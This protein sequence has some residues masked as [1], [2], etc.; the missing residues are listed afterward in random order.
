MYSRD[1]FDC[2]TPMN[3]FIDSDSFDP[4][5]VNN[6]KIAE[7]L[8][9]FRENKQLRYYKTKEKTLN[10][11]LS[12][13]PDV[14]DLLENIILGHCKMF[15]VDY[16]F[17]KD[18]YFPD[19][20][21][22][23]YAEKIFDDYEHNAQTKA[24]IL[25]LLAHNGISVGGNCSI[26][27]TNDE[28]LLSHRNEL[29]SHRISFSLFGLKTENSICIF[30]LNEASL[31]LDLFFKANGHYYSKES[32]DLTMG[33]WYHLSSYEKMPHI[34]GFNDP[35]MT[36]LFNR[37]SFA[38]HCL[39]EIGIQNFKKVT[40][41]N[42]YITIYNLTYLIS[43][44]TGIFDNL[45][46]KTASSL[47]FKTKHPEVI[48][49]KNNQKK[50]RDYVNVEYPKLFEYIHNSD[51]FISLIHEFREFAIHREGFDS[52]TFNNGDE[53]KGFFTCLVKLP[54]NMNNAIDLIKKNEGNSNVYYPFSG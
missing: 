29:L 10:P 45:A 18:L 43:L 1:I 49:L 30:S 22:N 31:V 8:L 37:M 50:F 53:N 42:A 13:I 34:F 47:H 41:N 23:Y 9:L 26:Y 15:D 3:I 46:I 28:K 2:P 19:R 32:R 33:S 48:T 38:L 44:I 36:G 11:L 17:S 35:I 20:V 4:P 21:F 54:P 14:N 16:N 12:S 51:S 5:Q 25:P 24:K 40:P 27:I 52:L 7:K 6:E 39:D